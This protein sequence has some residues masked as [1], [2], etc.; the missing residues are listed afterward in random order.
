[1]NKEKTPKIEQTLMLKILHEDKIVKIILFLMWLITFIT[2]VG[3]CAYNNYLQSDI[4]TSTQEINIDGIET[5][6]NST[7]KIGDDIY[8]LNG[9]GK[10]EKSQ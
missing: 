1:M 2:L 6:D 10:W 4:G 3:A 8:R 7:I 9:E 5:L